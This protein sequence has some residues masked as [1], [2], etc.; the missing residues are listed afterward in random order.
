MFCKILPGYI[1]VTGYDVH[2]SRGNAHLRDQLC[3]AKRGQRRELCRLHDNRIS[4]SE[5]RTKLPAGK[6]QREVP[7]H[8]LPDYANRLADRANQR[9]ETNVF[10]TQVW[11]AWSLVGNVKWYQD[12]TT[13]RAIELQRVPDIQLIGI[14]QPLPGVPG[15]FS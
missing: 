4:G 11:D 7:G 12:L 2:D 15:A 1:P 6:H 10:V 14:R 5:R 3:N 13:S 8:N 9:A